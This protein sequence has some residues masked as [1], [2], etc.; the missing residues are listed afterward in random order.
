MAGKKF[1]F[2]LENVLRLRHHEVERAEDVLTHR[3]QQRVAQEACVEQ[4]HQRLC[5]LVSKGVGGQTIGPQALRQYDAFRQDAR[6]AYEEA[7]QQL[8]RLRK[9]EAQA[10]EQLVQRKQA[11]EALQTLHDRKETEHLKE[12]ESAE[13]AFLDEQAIAGFYR[14]KQAPYI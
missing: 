1:S 9:L 13:M 5:E 4:A 8:E 10:R 6:R 7:Q 14:K 3:V 11:E 12:Q 2:P